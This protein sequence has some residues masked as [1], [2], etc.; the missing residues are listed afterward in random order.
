MH[1]PVI[2]TDKVVHDL[3]INSEYLNIQLR[4]TFSDFNI[5]TDGVLDRKKLAKIVFS[6]RKYLKKLESITHPLVIDEVMKFL[7]N[8]DAKPSLLFLFLFFMKYTGAICLTKL[9]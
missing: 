9:L 4:K 3:F 7:S 2:D 8:T 5:Y 6:D 1:Y